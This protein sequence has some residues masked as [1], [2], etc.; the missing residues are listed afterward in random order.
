MGSTRW[1]WLAVGSGVALV[2]LLSVDWYGFRILGTFDG[3]RQ[4]ISA[5]ELNAWQAFRVIDAV[6]FLLAVVPIAAVVIDSTAGRRR[7]S[8]AGGIAIA[9]AGALASGL[10]LFR[11][12]VPPIAQSSGAGVRTDL[13]P[14]VGIYF[15]LLTALGMTCGGIVHALAARRVRRLTKAPRDAN[16]PGASR[17]TTSRAA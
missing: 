6:L 5:G 10:V 15:S 4:W 17:A 2:L 3:R 11:I 9:T 16:G 12:A 13:I 8:R 7:G 1:R 14:H